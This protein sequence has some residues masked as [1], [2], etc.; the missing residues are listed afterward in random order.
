M[1]DEEKACKYIC[2]DTPCRTICEKAECYIAG[3]AEG[4]PKWHD[5]RE[6]PNDLPPKIMGLAISS[7]VLSENGNLVYYDYKN[8]TF[9]TSMITPINIIAWCELPEFEEKAE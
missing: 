1:T 9:A 2:D 3:L 5:L 4:K 7:Y 6:D 8:K